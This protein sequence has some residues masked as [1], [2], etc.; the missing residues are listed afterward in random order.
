MQGANINTLPSEY[1]ALICVKRTAAKQ[2]VIGGGDKMEPKGEHTCAKHVHIP[3]STY[4][5]SR[6]P[7]DS[8]SRLRT[9]QKS[10]SRGREAA[11]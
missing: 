5:S 7:P 9:L 4:M 11:L 10:S 2:V 6:N 3:S 1:F 8:S